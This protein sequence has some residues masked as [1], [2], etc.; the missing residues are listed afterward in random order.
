MFAIMMHIGMQEAIPKLPETISADL[1]DFLGCCF[2]IDA[3]ARTSA[4]ELLK[5]RWIC[6]EIESLS[7]GCSS[8]DA[9]VESG[10]KS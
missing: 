10:P 3:H 4:G 6:R 7:S 9:D 8:G 5:H 1:K 2:K